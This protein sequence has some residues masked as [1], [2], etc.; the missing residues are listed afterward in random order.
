MFTEGYEIYT[1]IDL[2]KQELLQ[3]YVNDTLSVFP[4]TNEEGIYKMQGAAVCIDNSTGY[5]T[6][7][8][9]GRDQNYPGYTL[10][11]AYQSFR[12]SGSA[13]KPLNVYAPFLG[14]GNNPDYP[15]DDSPMENGPVNSDGLYL[16]ETTIKE[17]LAW[18]SNVVPWKLYQEMTPEYGLSFL[19][20]MNFKKLGDDDDYMAASLGG[21]TYGVSAVEMASGF[22]TLAND[23]VYREPTTI[24]RIVDA[25]G[26]VIV[27]NTFRATRIYD[28][29]AARMISHIL[30]YGV[31]EGL[32][33]NAQIDNAIVA[34]KTGTT[35]DNKDGWIVGYSTYYTTAVWVG[36]D[37][38][39]S[40]PVLTGGTFPLYI[41]RGFMNDIHTG[42]KKTEFPEY[43]LY[44]DEVV[45]E[46][47]VTEE[48][49]TEAHSTGWQGDV[50]AESTGGDRDA[51]AGGD[52]DA[53]AQGD[54]NAEI[55]GG[56]VDATIE[57][58][59]NAA[60]K[61]DA[62]AT[63]GGDADAP[64]GGDMDAP[65]QSDIDALPGQDEDAT[66]QGDLDAD[67]TGG[68]EDAAPFLE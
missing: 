53:T 55:T 56:D 38:P 15:V 57:G 50:S 4:D 37:I 31:E 40:M 48:T 21:F 44:S 18:S 58:D 39:E 20:R 27:D 5:V 33:S 51:T 11:R 28:I 54:V 14:L 22:A 16:G 7:I 61:G 13:V 65:T 63:V 10:N 41:W 68:D 8:V 26:R 19:R 6:A 17:A 36:C 47:S 66:I 24:A 64:I 3:Q 43:E 49:E 9:G 67:I 30:Q 2:E 1:A 62:D 60:V 46:S 35:T 12:Q 34:A 59:G 25:D 29:N 45:E 32:A 23:G 52:I 42:L